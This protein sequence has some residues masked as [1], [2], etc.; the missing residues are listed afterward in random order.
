MRIAIMGAGGIGGTVGA[1]LTAA[2][3]DVT[4]IA[5]GAHL[6]A[7]RDQGLQLDSETLG[8]T[9][10]R[11]ASATDDPGEVG[12]V[13]VILLTTKLYDLEAAADL[14]RPMIGPDTPVI[15][16]LNGVDAPGRMEPIVGAE[17]VVGGVAYFT[18]NIIDPGVVRHVSGPQRIGF[19]ELDG[20]RSSRLDA[21][22]A[23]AQAAG[24]ETAYSDNI[25]DLLWRKFVLLAPV[26]GICALARQGVGFVRADAELRP[27][28]EDAIEEVVQVAAAKGF[29]VAEEKAKGMTFLDNSSPNLRPSMLVD[30]VGG[31]RLEL[32]SLSGTVVRMGHELGVDTPINRAI[33][34]A[35]TPFLSGSD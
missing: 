22:D 16:L 9:H 1:R 13:D 30:L 32:E 17:H 4:L 35:L 10:V 15:S 7:I 6:Q 8:D 23:A 14:C 34:A 3:E 28:L 25:Q 20:R 29:D 11:P 19:G 31:K 21:F 12:P 2:G 33:Y 5:R 18:A 24:I 27:L 26:A